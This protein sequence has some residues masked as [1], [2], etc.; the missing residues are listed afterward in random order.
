MLL[1]GVLA[2]LTSASVMA[3]V[4]S[5]NAV[6]YINVTIPGPGQFSIISDQLYANGQGV[7][8]TISP[9]L[10]A[11]VLDGTHAGLTFFKYTAGAYNIFGVEPTTPPAWSLDP[12]TSV[13]AASEVTL[14][15]GE[16]VY[17][18]NPNPTTTLTFVGSVPQGT[19]LNVTNSPGFNLISS[20]VPQAGAIDTVL[21]LTPANGDTIFL[22]DAQG[23]GVVGWNG[24]GWQT[25]TATDITPPN[26]TAPSPAVGTGFFYF[27]NIQSG[28]EVW[29]R[30]FTISQ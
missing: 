3:Q 9:M 16:A 15:P 25:A 6:G 1:S 20:V 23:Y 8:Q 13:N 4:Y 19:A 30:S 12:I 10:D 22:Y 14:N 27:A 18:Y 7:S 5:L 26:G 21:Q 24:V 28:T 11:Q 17:V 2:A 29:T